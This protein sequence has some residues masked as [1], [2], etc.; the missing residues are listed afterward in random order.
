MQCKAAR[1]LNA[2]T[3]L[4]QLSV[5]TDRPILWYTSLR[6]LAW[7]ANYNCDIDQTPWGCISLLIVFYL[8]IALQLIACDTRVCF[9]VDSCLA[10]H[11][12]GISVATVWQGCQRVFWMLPH[13]YNTCR[14]V[15][16]DWLTLWYT[17]R[18][19]IMHKQVF[20]APLLKW[21]IMPLTRAPV[22]NTF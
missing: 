14:F 10:S 3:Q 18:G 12:P 1:F 21:K 16:T 5:T 22:R 19:I 6:V 20:L 8:H 17:T 2:I 15:T 7:H 13:N 4:Q 9:S 11:S